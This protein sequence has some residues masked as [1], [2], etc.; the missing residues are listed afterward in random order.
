MSGAEGAGEERDL[1]VYEEVVSP[2]SSQIKQETVQSYC[3]A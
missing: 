3:K 1:P 2:S